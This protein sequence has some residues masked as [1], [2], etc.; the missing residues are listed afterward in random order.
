MRSVWLR[1]KKVS[2]LSRQG[3]KSK[4]SV[5]KGQ[6]EVLNDPLDI[7]LAAQGID[8]G[9]GSGLSLGADD[10]EEWRRTNRGSRH[11]KT[12]LTTEKVLDIRSRIAAG[13]RAVDLAREYR[14]TQQVVSAIKLGK[15]WA[16]L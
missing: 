9:A 15:S 1:F 6:V 13:E 3:G 2:I 16:W 11:Y 10:A 8:P 12:Q 14:V 7:Y 4:K 5:S